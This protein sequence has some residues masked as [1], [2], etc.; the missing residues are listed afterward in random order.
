MSTENTTPNMQLNFTLNGQL[1]NMRVGP[2]RRLLDILRLDQG[3]TGPKEGCS[4]GRC[5]ACTIQLDGAAV[6]A[7]LLLAYQ[8]QGK[9]V[10]TVEGLRSKP[11][12]QRVADSLIEHG[13]LQ[14]GYC[15][16]GIATSL[17]AALTQRPKASEGELEQAMHGNLCRCTGYS[18]LQQ[19]IKDLATPAPNN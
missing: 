16:P 17:T 4:I 9:E 7:C 5:G 6:P 18:G 19:V 11:A 13:A 14:C 8:V 10:I 3:L 15:I 12:F 1:L 2:A